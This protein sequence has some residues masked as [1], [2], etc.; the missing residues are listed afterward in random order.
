MSTG[1]GRSSERERNQRRDDG[2]DRGRQ[3]RKPAEIPARGWKDIAVRVKNEMTNDNLS[4]VAAGVAFY[5]FLAIFP[6][7]AAFVSLYGLV[8]SP[9]ELQEHVKTAQSLLPQQTADLIQTQLQRIAGGQQSQ[10]GWG[11]MISVVLALWSAAKGMKAMM[12]A[13]N[14][15]YDEQERRGTIKLNLVAILLTLGAILFVGVFLGLIALL[16]ALWGI[17]GLNDTIQAVLNYLRWPLLAI[18]AIFA[19]AVLYRYG[20]SR[21]RPQWRWV[22]WGAIAATVLWLAGSALFSLYVSNFGSYD[23]TYGSLGVVVILMMW[24][25]LCAYSVLL[26]SEV[27]AEMEHQTARDTTSGEERPRGRRGAYVADTVGERADA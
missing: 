22:S 15:T 2:R 27:N 20:P 25:L 7:L 5:A 3:A 12:Q 1:T 13:M 14:I 23:K 17:L 6:A 11:L 4:I 8:V 16:P 10:L 18:A 9:A 24:F 26:G 21:E 19:I